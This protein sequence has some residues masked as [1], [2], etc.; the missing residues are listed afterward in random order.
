MGVRATWR[1][2]SQFKQVLGQRG[3]VYLNL[4]EH[5]EALV[6]LSKSLEVKP[7]DAWVLGQRVEFILYFIF[8]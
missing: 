1:S 7:N 6:D 2:L 3:E 5:E 4:N 8:F